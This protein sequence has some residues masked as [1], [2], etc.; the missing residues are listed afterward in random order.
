MTI[1]DKI[2]EFTELLE[3]HQLEQL[4]I[5]KLDCEGNRHNRKVTI[6]EG[7]K[8]VKVDIGNS[9]RYMIELSTGNIYGIKAYGV[10][11]RGHHFGTLDTIHAYYWG[12]YRAHKREVE[13]G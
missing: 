4:K 3:L 9:G 11:H 10:I 8:Y 5:D 6:V 12:S 7:K 2:K 1:N 13:N